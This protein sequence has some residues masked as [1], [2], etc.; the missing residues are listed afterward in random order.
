[1]T[2]L[3]IPRVIFASSGGTVY[4]VTQRVSIREDH[5]TNPICSYGIHKLAIEK[6][7]QLFRSLNR[8]DSVCLRISNHYG[9][10]QDLSKPLG[11]VAHFSARAVRG[12]P[13]EIWGDGSVTRDYIHIEDVANAFARA[14]NYDGTERLMNIGTGRG[15]SLNALVRLIQKYLSHPVSVCYKPRRNFD[16]GANVLDIRCARRALKW[17]P[18]ISVEMGIQRMIQKAQE[19]QEHEPTASLVS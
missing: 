19:G 1:M 15:S 3:K 13:I 14:A 7:L 9:E 18:K 11:A 8:L 16:V 6:Y 10:D 4:G 2:S 17:E 5:P 12:L